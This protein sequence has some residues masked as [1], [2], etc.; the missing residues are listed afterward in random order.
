MAKPFHTQVPSRIA[1]VR[2]AAQV[3]PSEDL[4]PIWGE[5]HPPVVVSRL[6]PMGCWVK[7]HDEPGTPVQ[8]LGDLGVLDGRLVAHVGDELSNVP[9]LP[10]PG[11]LTR[12][13]PPT[14]LLE[15]ESSLGRLALPF[16][17]RAKNS[18]PLTSHPRVRCA[19]SRIGQSR[20]QS[21]KPRL[22]EPSVESRISQVSSEP[23]TRTSNS[24]EVTWTRGRSFLHPRS[25]FS[26]KR[27]ALWPRARTCCRR[28]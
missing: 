10:P 15:L 26:T 4:R 18:L 9:G 6:L 25:G 19:E 5:G 2:L 8:E 12:E 16:F 23:S 20:E 21:I 1:I 3:A 24:P 7:L 22:D 27:R 11:Q 13:E 14:L 17:G 28:A